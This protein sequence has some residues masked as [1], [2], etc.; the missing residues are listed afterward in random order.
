MSINGLSSYISL[1]IA[2]VTNAW[3]A[4]YLPMSSTAAFDNTG[5]PYNLDLIIS[6]GTFDAASYQTYS[7]VYLSVTNVL[8]YGVCFAILP[9]AVVHTWRE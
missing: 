9:A 7:P 3:Y 2:S 8:T 1:T 6:N 4:K 5:L